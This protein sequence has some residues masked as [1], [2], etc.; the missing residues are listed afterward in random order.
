MPDRRGFLAGLLAS[1]LVPVTSWADAGSPAYLAAARLPSGQYALCGLTSDGQ[2]LFQTDLP[3]RGHAAATHPHRP[4]A[5]A[6]ARRPG[7][8]ASIIDCTT[9]RAIAALET[10]PGSHFSGH[11]VFS[12]DG[13]VLFTS[14]NDFDNAR[15]MVG[16]WRVDGGHARIGSFPSGGVGPHD[17]KHLPGTDMLVVA[18]G[19]IETHPETGRAALN[20]ATMRANLSFLTAEGSIL[21]QTHAPRDWRKLSLRHL[22]V[23]ADGLVGVAGQWQAEAGT[24]PPLLATCRQGGE[25]D[26]LP[27]GQAHERDMLGYA[28]SIAFSGAG[29]LLAITGPRGGRALVFDVTRRALHTVVEEPDICGVAPSADGLVYSTGQG[30]FL[31]RGG[32]GA[33][34]TNS[35]NWD[36]HLVPVGA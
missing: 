12:R 31:A 34:Q 14:E 27:S 24:T 36:N 26:F 7:T 22:A 5:V 30:R 9:G 23:R 2:I 16:V 3:D 17:I 29:D 20:L 10:P 4:H 18:N 8:F 35:L 28:G 33:E 19:G 21:S 13:R 25:L 1:G 6:F 11:G 32:A 15:G